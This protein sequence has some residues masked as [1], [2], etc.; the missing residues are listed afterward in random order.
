MAKRSLFRR[1]VVLI[2]AAAVV[3]GSA[4]PVRAAEKAKVTVTGPLEV[5][6]GASVRLKASVTPAD[7]DQAVTWKSS[8][9]K[10]ATVSSSG[11][12]KGI[13]PGKV[14]ITAT[15]VK[16]SSLKKTVTVTVMKKAAAK[17]R[18]SAETKQLDLNGQKTV[19]LTAK[20][21]PSSASQHVS[22]KSSDRKVAKVDAKGLV[23]AVGTGKATITATAE[24]GSKVTGKITITVKNT[25][26]VKPK[27]YAL[28]V[29]N[30]YGY[31]EGLDVQ[32]TEVPKEIRTV[33][34]MLKGLSQEW[35]ITLRED[36]TANGIARAIKTAFGKA[37]KNDVCLFFY[38]GHGVSAE[39]APKILDSERGGLI[40]VDFEVLTGEKL[41]ATLKEACSGKVIVML[42][43]C[44]SGSVLH[45]DGTAGNPAAN[46]RGFTREMIDAFSRADDGLRENIGEL[47]DGKFTVL[48]A[49]D[50]LELGTTHD[51]GKDRCS[52]F[53]YFLLQAAGC[54]FPGGKYS[55]SMP[56]DT[57]GDG[58]L[59]L[60]ETYS[61]VYGKVL[62]DCGQHVQKYGKGSFVLFERGGAK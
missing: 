52:A 33:R 38:A 36:L 15:S 31:P 14:K 44:G 34:T 53:A 35:Q 55:G 48:T 7:A 40:G 20:V 51:F 50:Y 24:D 3:L 59:T 60:N 12:V 58:R 39:E 54:G 29:G 13:A 16:D 23:T 62:E 21:S 27:Y 19:A 46:A 6:P 56:A 4:G 28:L 37:E 9:K 47:R 25:A 41:A 8:D 22:W 26:P 57:D 30:G 42:N 11:R 45:Q 10:I 17:I 49:C 5:A 18:V 1:I 43:S 61:W 2:L 32:L